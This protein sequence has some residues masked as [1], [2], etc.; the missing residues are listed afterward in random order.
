MI[1]FIIQNNVSI[2]FT[3]VALLFTLGVSHGLDPDHIAIIDGMTLQQNSVNSP[4]TKWVG[5]L[6][7]IGHGLVITVIALFISLISHQI[8]VPIWLSCI[9]EWIPVVIMLLVGF[10]NIKF[11]TSKSENK[12]ASWRATFIPNRLKNSTSPLSVIF[13]GVLFATVF[14][15]ATQAATWGLAAS[16]Q[17]KPLTS[18]LIGLIFSAG[19]ILIDSIDGRILTKTLN[20]TSGKSKSINY[21]KL[22]GW[23]VVLMSFSIALYKIASSFFPIIKLSANINLLIGLMFMFLIVAIYFSTLFK[24][25]KASLN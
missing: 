11:L 3:E 9:A 15:T 5:T 25:S 21:R 23:A 10:M 8:T 13:I 18:L 6:F 2:T 12:P 22:I 4:F 1:E 17:G 19:M 20:K 14:D 7:S 24:R 16:Q